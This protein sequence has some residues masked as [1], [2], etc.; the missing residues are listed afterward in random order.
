MHLW[1]DMSQVGDSADQG[2]PLLHVGGSAGWHFVQN[3]LCW[4]I[5]LSSTWSLIL[6]QARPGLSST[7][8]QGCKR[9][10]RLPGL[11]GSSLK[12]AQHDFRNILLAKP[13]LEA[14][15]VHHLSVPAIT[16]PG[17]GEEAQAI[18]VGWMYRRQ[19]DGWK[20]LGFS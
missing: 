6:H 3:G 8:R 1:S 12:L 9:E 10:Q 15:L 7:W 5:W 4:R 20:F 11:L 19:D 17:T 18:F 2:W 14:G 16:V 13:S